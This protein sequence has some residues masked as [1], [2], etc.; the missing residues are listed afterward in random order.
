MEHDF[1]R[2]AVLI[3]VLGVGAQWLAW[4]L[5]FPAIILLTVAG[6]AA[7]PG[8][9]LMHPERELGGLFEPL[10]GLF[11]AVILFEGGLNLKLHEVRDAGAG[12]RRLV[13][14][15]V[16]LSWGLT[17]VLAH[18]VGQLSWPVALLFGAISVVT[19]PTVIMP[20]LRQAR[21]HRR[22]S[23]YLKWE[24]IV[25][26]PIGALLAVLI[27]E[28]FVFRRGQVPLS[29]AALGVLLALGIAVLLGGG[30]GYGLGRA[31][32]SG[33]IPEFLK[34]PVILV[35]VLTVYVLAN[36][37]Q[38]ES[39]LLAA[40]A[41]GLVLAN[42]RLPSIEDL[43]R[44]NEYL[45]VLLV[46][47]VFILLTADL[48][49][50]RLTRLDWHAALLIIAVILIVRPVAV[51]LSTIG[52]G[53][54]WRERALMAW[55][56][57][58]G[59]VAAATAGFF[60]PRMAQAGYGDA[61]ELVPLVFALIAATVILHGLSLGWVGRRLRLASEK[62]TGVLIVGASPWTVELARTLSDLDVPVLI[63]DASWSR[64]R[65]AR[66]SGQRVY[67]GEILSELREQALELSDIASLLAAT[68]NDAYNALVCTHFAPELGTHAVFQLPMHSGTQDDPKAL[69]PSARG[70]I[71]FGEDAVFEELLRRY[72][73]GWRFQ[74]TRLTETFNYERYTESC[75]AHM[76]PILLVHP[77]GNV[78]I[79]AQSNPLVPKP[80]DTFLSF[81]PPHEQQATLTASGPERQRQVSAPT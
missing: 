27:F 35:T 61:K 5:N 24:G 81:C 25:N 29:T 75:G 2:I 68:P 20:L 9:G 41:L 60:A 19:G 69:A 53:M 13:T 77:D 30:I 46:S 12:L 52:A 62:A 23:S 67:F 63:V 54:P 80:G 40:T 38:R 79:S 78:T 18:W 66:L 65:H 11:V 64:L 10:I 14:L 74:K 6:L 73:A 21:L 76:V 16:A 17:T 57:P 4:R 8:L 34:A 32:R 39:G 47:G 43:R 44:F 36:R 31:F 56:A 26:D 7:G 45:S 1:P 37:L 33:S 72:Y 3:G 55:I 51:V 59:I 71:A 58:R 22:A 49:T 48:D 15:G 28:Y 42:L 70:T 50:A